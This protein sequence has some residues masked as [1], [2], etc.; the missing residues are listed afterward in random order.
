[1][2]IE[3]LWHIRALS[4]TLWSGAV[5]IGLGVGT[6]EKN[7]VPAVLLLTILFPFWFAWIDSTYQRWYRRFR[8][9]EEAISRFIFDPEFELPATRSRMSLRQSIEEGVV[10]FP[11]FD[12]FAHGTYGPD[13][14][15]IRWETSRFSNLADPTPVIV[16]G[17][18]LATS[19]VLIAIKILQS[20]WWVAP[21]TVAV[22]LVLLGLAGAVVKWRIFAQSREHTSRTHAA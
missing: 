12:M 6:D 7:V 15:K 2:V 1:M 14:P 5:A 4:V 17:V 11:V 8:A 21:A 3:R 10:S 13:H 9:R 22:V 16:Y 19:T 20:L 18:Q